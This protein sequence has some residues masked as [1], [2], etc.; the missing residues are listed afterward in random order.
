MKCP[1][2]GGLDLRVLE[3]RSSRD[4]VAIR[5]RRE[6]AQCSRRFTTFEGLEKPRLLVVKRN[7]TRAEFDREKVLSG[8]IIACGKRPVTL[9]TL[10]QAVEEMER[11]LYDLG[12]D[13][14]TS[15]EIAER[16]MA[17]LWRIDKVAFVRFTSVFGEFGSPDEFLQLVDEVNRLQALTDGPPPS[18]DTVC[19]RV[20]G[21]QLILD[22]EE[23]ILMSTEKATSNR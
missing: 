4:G 8:M 3:S 5:R 20:I 18:V 17:A 16:V 13:E 14:V 12:D 6:C 2:C 19:P 21:K 22:L 10:R 1:F 23:G 15:H 9:E 11:E 7:G